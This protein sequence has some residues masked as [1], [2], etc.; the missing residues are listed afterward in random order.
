MNRVMIRIIPALLALLFA[1]TGMAQSVVRG[2]YLQTLTDDS[3]IVRWR[4]DLA[5]V[6]VVRYGL[7]A[8]ALTSTA[9]AGGSR[10]EHTVQVSGLTA[11]TEYFYSVGDSGGPIEGNADYHF[12]TAPLPG[13]PAAT[14]IWVIGDSGTANANAQN[15]RIAFENWS[16]SSPAD[17]MMMLGDNA[18]NDGTDSEYQAAV[19]AMY[20]DLLRRLP[21][22]STL[23]N[24]DG[25]SADSGTQSGP[26]FDI[27]NFPVAGEAGGI[28]SGTEA[29]YSFDYGNIHVVV[30]DS[31]DTDRSPGGNMLQ[32]LEADLA[33]ND[34]PWV[35]AIWHHP[36]YTKGSH[37]SDTEGG[38]IDMR[39]NA[40]P[41]LEAWGVDLVMT[42]HS[43][44]YE[45]SYLLDGHYGSSGT[46]DPVQHILDPGDGSTGGDGAYEK[47]DVVA[48]ENAGAVYAVAG[49]SG[50]VSGV[51]GDWPHV[52]MT[53]YLTV[54]GSLVLDVAGN[55][56]DVVFIDDG[57]SVLDDFTL[58]KTPDLQAPIIA[59]AR[60]EDG[61]HVIV[62]YTERV[63]AA[64]ATDSA[65]YSIPGLSVSN[66]ALL[67]GNKSVRLTTSA[68]T[69]GASYLL[70]VN[71]VMDENG[72]AI[73]PNS[74]F[75]FDFIQQMT[76]SFQDGLAPDPGYD[77]TSDA[78]IREASPDTG[79]GT[80]TTL[81]VDGDEPS[82]TGTDMN[83]VIG[84]DVSDIPATATVDAASIHL[85]TLN[86][87][88][89][90]SCYGLLRAWNQSGVT[91]NDAS[92]GNAWGSPGAEA[93]SD[94]DSLLLCTFNAGST[95][96]LTINLNADGIALVQSWV[97]G[98]LANNGIV[99]SDTVT[100]NGADFDSS[101]SVTAVNRPRLEVTYTVPVAPP[102]QPP[103]ASFTDNCTDLDCSFTD[104][105]TDADGTIVG[106]SWNFGDGNSSTLQNPSHSFA[107][108]GSYTVELT[109]TDNEGAT[110]VTSHQVNV[111]VPPPFTDVLANADI[112]ASGT[113][114]G[115]YI[116]THADDGA[117]Q[118]VTERESGGKKQNRFSFLVHTWLFDLP[119]NAMATVYAN[120]WSGGS[121][122]DDF[123]VS[124]S[125]DNASYSDLF[126][127]TSTDSVNVE[128]A[129]IPAVV[130]GTFYI[131]VKDT[132][133]T[134]G[135][136]TLDTF[137]VDQ[138][139][140]RTDFAGGDP[141]AAPT[142]LAASAAGSDRVSLLWADNAMDETGFRIQ[143]S[144]D[145]VSF[146]DV[147]TNLADD[148]TF[149]DV[150]LAASTTYWYRVYAFNA[151]GDSAYSNEDSAITD[152]GPAI[153]LNL[154]GY[155]S[156]GRHVVD[157]DWLGTTT[158]NV[159]IFRDGGLLA[160]VP[161]TGAHTDNTGNK[162][163]R[164]YDY[165]VC[166]AGTANCSA[167]ES[168]SF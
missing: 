31:Y 32:W 11:A 103:T 78:Y 61:T 42:G 88:G 71:N 107:A 49:S 87:G 29:Y 130:S 145:G 70:T 12:G 118:S 83:I 14:R 7:S 54:L 120:A 92:L 146:S 40:L 57:G 127:V 158:A 154:A 133:Q 67:A 128:S 135:N 15:V 51:Q 8:A 4:T 3:V 131:R 106:W 34:K 141:P 66:A 112:P 52:A 30:L 28:A 132:D 59:D 139:Y 114:S 44:S 151:A 75:G 162:G 47:P 116:D 48:A 72:N 99:V 90:Y 13:T 164:T 5:T 147:G 55:Q 142:S 150:G 105:S 125:T 77:G 9:S 124:W 123:V 97:D 104:T 56:L 80:A 157:L 160:T 115:T 18:Y 121:A 94:R 25:H 21:V 20:Q 110:D 46:L 165:Q 16:A 35:I 153:T 84:W 10:T 19:F 76:V 26:Y 58:M 63:D 36:P 168:I 98:T 85:N 50:K 93:A 39:Q 69:P 24:H 119:A 65:N 73:A 37:D 95:G 122:E 137:Y 143:R 79:Y 2:P 33:F 108:D 91:W 62:D 140:V 113:V 81:Q 111:S 117:V 166:E 27:F 149:T 86:V 138:L 144:D 1:A 64:T 129:I 155:K 96:P 156:K 82:G 101:E 41:I 109:I 60:A 38:L 23:G 74:Q 6:S 167:V 161:D 17:F 148:T 43:H 159:D 22:W 89:P 134:P 53:T 102:N 152:A 100:G 68:M 45:R 136:R 163:T 126:T